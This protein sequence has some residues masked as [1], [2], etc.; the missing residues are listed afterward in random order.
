MNQGGS[1]MEP[2]RRTRRQ[3]AAMA[4]TVVLAVYFTLAVFK[5]AREPNALQVN[6]RAYYHSGQAFGLGLDPYD[7]HVLYKLAGDRYVLPFV[8]PPLTLHVFH[9]LTEFKFVTAFRVFLALKCAGLVLLL[10]FWPVLAVSYPNQFGVRSIKLF[11]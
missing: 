7:S 6:L 5:I 1:A 2:G 4:V 10:F 9:P 8:Y 3:R 11:L